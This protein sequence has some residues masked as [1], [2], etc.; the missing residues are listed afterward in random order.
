VLFALAP[1]REPHLARHPD[2][3]LELEAAVLGVSAGPVDGDLDALR[4]DL[5]RELQ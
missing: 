2:G 1:Q 3:S 4:P 5:E